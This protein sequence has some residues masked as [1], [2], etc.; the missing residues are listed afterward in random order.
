MPR[1]RNKIKAK[2]LVK[3]LIK[4][5]ASQSKTARELGMSQQA[6]YDQVKNN[7]LVK[8]GLEA[9]LEALEKAGANDAA[10]ATVIAEGMKAEKTVSVEDNR[11]DSEGTRGGQAY[12][13]ITEPD[14]NA[15]LKA[16]EQYLKVK[17]L[18]DNGKDVGDDNRTQLV[19]VMGERGKD[20]L[21]DII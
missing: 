20:A 15:R 9:Y 1:T 4:H 14:H 16:N 13:K 7:P 21:L 2:K 19:I 17:K 3:T 12:T 5:G 8:S 18:L 6:V 10:S 11:S